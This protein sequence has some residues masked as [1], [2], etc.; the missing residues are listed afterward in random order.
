MKSDKSSIVKR[1]EKYLSGEDI[2]LTSEEEKILNRWEKANELLSAKKP[3]T[4]VR[5][6]IAFRFHVSK[7]TAENDLTN[8]MEVFGRTK[9]INKTYLYHLHLERLDQDIERYRTSIFFQKDEDGKLISREPTSK[10]M[11]SL[12]K[13]HD[14]Y[15]YALH[16]MPEQSKSKDLPPPMYVYNL[17]PGVFMGAPM[18]IADALRQADQIIDAEYTLLNEQQ[19]LQ[20]PRSTDTGDDDA[21]AAPDDQDDQGE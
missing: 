3:W 14:A 20:S 7:F 12:A 9:R 13:M 21:G 16:S 8:T 18:P 2:L 10:E 4:E 17:P 19:S 1:I 15:N 5:D 11:Q 6:F